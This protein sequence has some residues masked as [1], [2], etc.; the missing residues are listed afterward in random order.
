MG[1]VTGVVGGLMRSS[2]GRLLAIVAKTNVRMIAAG[3]I[4]SVVPGVVNSIAR[5]IA[6]TVVSNVVETLLPVLV[7]SLAAVFVSRVVTY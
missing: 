2:F 5:S 3:A 4:A 7:T 6:T 1:V